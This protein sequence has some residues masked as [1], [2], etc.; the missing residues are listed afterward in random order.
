MSLI[1]SKVVV[2]LLCLLPLI[3]IWYFDYLPLQD[4]PNHL[5]RL[6]ILSHYE[7]SDFYKQFFTVNFFK[8]I[9]PLPYLTLDLFVT[10]LSHFLDV[11]SA[12]RVF[13]SLYIFLYITGL[14][15]LARQLKLDFGLLG[16]LNLPVMYSSFF[17][18]GFL[19]FMF[20]IPLFL[21]TV[22]ALA[23]YQ[24]TRNMAYVVVIAIFSLLIYLSHI[25]TLLLFLIFL[26]VYL[27]AGRLKI[28]EYAYLLIAVLPSFVF[29]LNYLVLSTNYRPLDSV[30]YESIS[31]PLF[32][33]LVL[34]TSPFSYL[35][36][37]LIVIYSLLYAF[38][39]FIISRNSSSVDKFYL[40]FSLLL[41]FTYFVLPLKAVN[42]HSIDG[43]YID[44]RVLLFSLILFPLSLRITD[45]R[46]IDL[47]KVIL[48]ILFFMS[49]SGLLH[50]FSD[51][52]RNFSASCARA[53][54]PR[55]SVFQINVMPA[56]SGIRPYSSAWG[57]FCK[58]REILTPYL[59][60]GTHIPV[61]YKYRPPALTEFQIGRGNAERDRDFLNK[62]RDNY[63]YILFMGNDQKTEDLIGTVSQKMCVDKSVGLY[64]IN[65]RG[66]IHS[67]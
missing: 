41:L 6:S 58:E 27:F 3:P 7:H 65:R 35:S 9:S 66:D 13:I 11:D 18:F 33:K 32:Y 63:D 53:I 56:E 4:Y 37:N 25:F 29:S 46:N 20:S 52:N 38:A 45:N 43:Y 49:F 30:R 22:W 8:G 10:R 40:I 26:V 12:M 54:K 1:R 55:S 24:G 16:L 34:L 5:A 59:F 36:F 44:V 57:F 48:Y 67:K 21:V 31:K 50:S 2:L 15:L 19:N 51:F 42:G 47:A 64:E 39:L 28:K 61:T 62:L 17:H 60:T 23:K 14:F